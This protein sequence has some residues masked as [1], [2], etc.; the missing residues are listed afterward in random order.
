MKRILII[1]DDET[2]AAIE[3][4]YLAVNEF[5][6]D[7]AA[8]G[9][10]GIAKGRSGRYDLILLDLMLPGTDGFTVCRALRETLD[11][12]ISD[13]NCQ[14]GGHRQDQGAGHGGGRLHHKTLFA[15]CAGG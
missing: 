3:R 6:V 12:P 11:I 5:E 7:I 4:D 9:P 10:E 2:I 15:Q 14:A 8:T 1:E 13:G